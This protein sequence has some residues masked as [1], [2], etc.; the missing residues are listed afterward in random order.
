MMWP[1]IGLSCAAAAG[2]DDIAA[3]AGADGMS[4][5]VSPRALGPSPPGLMWLMVALGTGERSGE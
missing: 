2:A 5:A 1:F 4:A 3:A